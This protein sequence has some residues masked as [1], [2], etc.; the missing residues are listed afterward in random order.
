MTFSQKLSTSRTLSVNRLQYHVR[1]W[2]APGAPQLFLLHGWLDASASFQFIVDAFKEDWHIIAPDWR[3]CGRSQWNA[4]GTGYRFSDLLADLDVLIDQLG[5]RQP[6][7]LVGHS[8]GANV[9]VHYA[10]LRPEKIRRVVSL[11]GFGPLLRKNET[12]EPPVAKMV[13]WFDELKAVRPFPSYATFEDAAAELQ[14]KNRRLSEVQ[15]QFLS[16]EFYVP[17]EAG[18][19]QRLGDPVYKVREVGRYR[20]EDVDAAWANVSAPIL[21]VSAADERDKDPAA[22]VFRERYRI[23]RD[24]REEIVPD[25]GHMIHHDQP[26]KLAGYMEAFCANGP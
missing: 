13:G 26:V 10:G 5:S 1:Q 17:D 16:R 20:R 24:F 4:G 6:I 25:C 2:G 11:E 14:R 22:A 18:R 23:F 21:H 9:A 15:A 12:T 7:N 8:M 19:M 3:G